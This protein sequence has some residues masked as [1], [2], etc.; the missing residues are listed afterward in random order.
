VIDGLSTGSPGELGLLEV[1]ATD[2]TS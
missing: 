1:L 2:A